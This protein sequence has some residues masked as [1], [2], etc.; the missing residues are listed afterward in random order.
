[1]PIIPANIPRPHYTE[2]G[3]LSP[4]KDTIPLAYPIGPPE[5]YDKFLADGMRNAGRLAAES[6]QYAVSLVKPGITT[7]EIDDKVTEWVFSHRCYPSSLNYGQFPG[8]L[9]TSVNNV[10]SHGVPNEYF[11]LEY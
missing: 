8:S 9:C 1:M 7:R 11:P 5:W 6:L 3:G 4:W 10:L 2:T